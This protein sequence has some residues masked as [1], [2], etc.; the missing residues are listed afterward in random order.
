MMLHFRLTRRWLCVVVM[1][2][3][4]GVVGTAG[5]AGFDPNELPAD[6]ARGGVAVM[7]GVEGVEQV[8]GAVGLAE[9]GGWL[10]LVVVE[11]EGGEEQRERMRRTVMEAGMGGRVLVTDSIGGGVPV[12]DD[13]AQLVVADLDA[14]GAGGVERDEAEAGLWRAV[15]PFGLLWVRKG[16]EWSGRVK[17]LPAEMDGWYSYDYAAAGNPI[18]HDTAL[19][20]ANTL[21]WSGGASAYAQGGMMADVGMR[22]SDGA[23]LYVE[24]GVEDAGHEGRDAKGHWLVCRDAF[25]GVM[26]WRRPLSDDTGVPGQHALLAEE[27]RAWLQLERDGPM[28]ALEL[29]A[30]EEVQRY[31][32]GLSAKTLRDEKGKPRRMNAKRTPSGGSLIAR[33]S[34]DHLVQCDGLDLVCLDTKSGERRWAKEGEGGAGGAG[35]NVLWFVVGDGRVYYAEA[36]EPWMELRGA[37]MFA[38]DAVVACDLETGEEVWR[39]E[40]LK[41][42]ASTRMVFADGDLYVPHFGRDGDEKN[43]NGL[44]FYTG[45]RQEWRVI[46]LDGETGEVVWANDEPR[47]AKAHYQVAMK[48]PEW[49]FMILGQDGV[50]YRAESGEYVGKVGF[51]P[52]DGCGEVRGTPEYLFYTMDFL[53]FDEDGKVRQ[54]DPG[55]GRSSCDTGVFPGYGAVHTTPS[56]CGCNE[57]LPGYN[58]FTR[59]ELPGAVE[60][61]RRRVKGAAFDGDVN[62]E[63]V[64]P[65]PMALG[66]AARSLWT[67]VAGPERPEPRWRTGPLASFGGGAIGEDWSIDDWAEGPVTSPTVGP[68]GVYVADRRGGTVIALDPDTGEVRWRYPIG[69]LLDGPPTVVGDL[70][71]TGS[72]DGWVYALRAEDGRL[73]WRF[74]AARANSFATEDS[75]L[76]SRWPVGASVLLYKGSLYAIAGRHSSVDDGMWVW[77]LD[78]ATGEPRGHTRIHTDP[79]AYGPHNETNFGGNRRSRDL[80]L[81]AGDQVMHRREAI[82]LALTA[83]VW[84]TER[85]VADDLGVPFVEPAR[86]V[87]QARQHLLNT[88]RTSF[89]RFFSAGWTYPRHTAADEE[90]PKRGSKS[91]SAMTIALTDDSLVSAGKGLQVYDLMEDHRAAGK[92]RGWVKLETLADRKNWQDMPDALAIAAPP[93]SASKGEGRVYLATADRGLRVHRLDNLEPLHLVEL[94]ARVIR[95][96]LAVG[97]GRVYVTLR[98]GTVMCLGDGG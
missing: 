51:G 21:R 26:R 79:E 78:P 57:Y 72:Y 28:V 14:M 95:H 5:A 41:G 60:E 42:R 2:A 64:A 94:P 63:G 38:V 25:S 81:G 30:G 23:V 76:A 22:L 61:G 92:P 62:V 84:V 90:P 74:L 69:G 9:R 87:V 96:G 55:M 82:D 37:S 52:F 39:Y 75:S 56:Q 32:R 33:L 45:Y 54:V 6:A 53:S 59:A 1:L 68:G 44:G 88:R 19:D 16:G 13:F 4:V 65:W 83:G 86:P 40:G 36:A 46:R 24:R 34:E 17:P 12:M 97:Q 70:V 50:R 80:L 48:H 29:G 10:V 47:T 91:I 77:R 3:W 43:R 67:Q 66:N 20:V 93:E 31:E 18:S 73:A 27:G 8:R 71:V 11:G 85:A 7:M 58:S 98:D 49:G 15:A 89:G 35:M